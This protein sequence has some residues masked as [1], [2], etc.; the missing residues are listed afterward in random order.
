M[1]KRQEYGPKLAEINSI[2]GE[3]WR[4]V[5]K[6]Q[7]ELNQLEAAATSM[8]ASLDGAKKDMK[9][10]KS[11]RTV[12]YANIL[13]KLG[14][15]DKVKKLLKDVNDSLLLGDNVQRYAS[16][17]AEYGDAQTDDKDVSA[18]NEDTQPKKK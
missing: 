2:S 17:E 18:D 12:K 6:E 3:I 7:L 9:Q 13:A 16:L 8:K 14:Q 15:A 11:N 5:A 4:Q 1:Y 10:A